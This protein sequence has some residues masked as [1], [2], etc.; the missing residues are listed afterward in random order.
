MYIYETIKAGPLH[1]VVVYPKLTRQEQRQRGPRTRI[2]DAARARLNLKKSFEKLEALIAA[3]FWRGFW[4]VTLTYR[5]ADLPES[6]EAAQKILAGKFIP[7][8]RKHW[9]LHGAAPKYI[10]CTQSVQSDGSRRWHHH[11]VLNR[12]GS[13]DFDVLRSLWTWGD[14]I[15]VE[16]R[17]C[18]GRDQITDKARY[19]THE[20]RDHG[21]QKKGAREWTP[22]K[23][24]TRP[25][26]ESCEVPE[27]VVPQAPMGAEVL[28]AESPRNEYGGYHYLKYWLQAG[29]P[30]PAPVENFLA[31]GEGIT[32]EHRATKIPV[33]TDRGRRTG[34]SLDRQ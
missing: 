2:T 32:F 9:Q 25:T 28:D 26:V 17:W 8:V 12:C 15:G 13:D 5:D 34:R 21:K 22:S 29:P 6:R 4:W 1:R 7:R 3:N 16:I 30:E 33:H 23:N 20:A 31:S 27:D 19:M 24:L 10:Y 11:M 14:E 18:S